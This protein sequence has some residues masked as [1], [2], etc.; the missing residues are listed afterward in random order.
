MNCR[1]CE[2]IH[3]FDADYPMRRATRDNKGGFPRCDWHW[4]FICSFCGKPRH[5]NGITWCEETQNF[6]CISCARSHRLDRRE[7]WNWKYYYTIECAKCSERHPALDYL[8]FLGKHPWQLHPAL[9]K[10]SEGLDPETEP[11]KLWVSEFVPLKKAAVTEEDISRAWDKIA[12]EWIGYYDEY[13]DVN[14]RYILDPVIFR[15]AG[16][17]AGLSV[18]DA[19]CGNGYLCRLL[20]KKGARMAGVDLSKR[21]IEIAKQKENETHLGIAYHK[22]SLCNLAMF[23]DEAFDIVVSNLVLMDLPDLEK[24]F[25]ELQRVLKKGGKLIF[26]IMHPC[27]SSAPVRGSLRV[28]QD[29]D[30]KEDWLYWK[31]DRYFDRSLEIW[32]RIDWSPVYSYHRPLADYINALIRNGLTLTHFEEPIPSYKDMMEHYREFGN[33]C[34]RIPW[35]LVIGAKKL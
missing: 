11:Q 9:R 31:I 29:S 20:A 12:D 13:G 27:F 21:L 16:S 35:F 19:G 7:F 17:V 15:F 3:S 18:L 14:R 23:K 25:Q 28:P 8:E 32:G 1:Y 34:D 4:R 24:A 2:I 5:F 30:R 33:E 10:R 6:T 22:G 26:S